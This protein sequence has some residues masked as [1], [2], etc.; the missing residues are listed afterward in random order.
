MNLARG[1]LVLFVSPERFGTLADV[2]AKSLVKPPHGFVQAARDIR[3]AI[4]TSVAMV[5]GTILVGWLSGM[6]LTKGFGP[7]PDATSTVCQFGG[8]GIL[9]WATLSKQGWNIQ[10]FNG[11]TLPE[12]LDR[13]IYRG[14]YVFGTWL[15]VLSLAWS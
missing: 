14:L 15:L 11:N 10:T 12:R 4:A 13:Y 7:A 6:L 9:L 8:A 3:R 2:D 1:I 5:L